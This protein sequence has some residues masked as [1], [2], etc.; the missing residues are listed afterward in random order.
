MDCAKIKLNI[1]AVFSSL[2]RHEI[3]RDFAKGAISNLKQIVKSSN[4]EII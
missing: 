3:A 4:T 2:G 1:C